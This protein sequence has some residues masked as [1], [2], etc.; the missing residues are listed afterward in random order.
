MS[1]AARD[2]QKASELGPLKDAD[3]FTFAMALVD[4]GNEAHARSLLTA[5]AEKYPAKAIYIYWLGRLDYSQRRYDGAIEK[6]TRASKLDPQ[7]ARVWDSLGLAFDMQGQTDQALEAFQKAA[8]LN[9]TQPHPGPWPPH[10]LGF[11][12][13]RMDRPQAAE[14]ALRESLRYDPRLAQTH[15]HLGRTLEKEARD[16]EAIEEYRSAISADTS[17][18][19]ACYSLA[20]LYRKLNR[21]A[22]SAAMFAEYKKRKQ[23]P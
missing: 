1:A 12:L 16:A 5:L 8:K 3:S 18:A 23:T 4:L 19:D 14:A 22:E 9:R 2:F 20:L 17:S 15:Y 21:E 6:L 7:S 11:L 13:L 10:N